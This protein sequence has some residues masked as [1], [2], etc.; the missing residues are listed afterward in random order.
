MDNYVKTNGGGCD[1]L[2][3][4]QRWVIPAATVKGLANDQALVNTL[5]ATS[6]RALPPGIHVHLNRDKTVAVAIGTLP[7]GFQWPEDE[8]GS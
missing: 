2:V 4:G 6:G 7:P 8:V 5:V 1:M 3:N